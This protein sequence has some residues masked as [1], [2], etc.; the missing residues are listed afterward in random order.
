VFKGHVIRRR[1]DERS[2]SDHAIGKGGDDKFVVFTWL[3]EYVT[4]DL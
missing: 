2:F 1:A 4:E 3:G